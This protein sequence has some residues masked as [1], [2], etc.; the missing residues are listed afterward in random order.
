MQRG[1]DAILKDSVIATYGAL[2]FAVPSAGMDVEALA[3]MVGELP[4]RTTLHELDAR[5]GQRL[6]LRQH[7]DFCEAFQFEDSVLARFYEL[8]ESRTVEKVSKHPYLLTY[9]RVRCIQCT[10]SES[11]KTQNS[12]GEWSRTGKLR[13][14]VALS[15]ASLGRPWETGEEFIIGLEGDHSTLVKLPDYCR[16]K[17]YDRISDVLEKFLTVANEVIA[18]RFRLLSTSS[19]SHSSEGKLLISDS[20]K[21]KYNAFRLE[22][23]MTLSEEE[24]QKGKERAGRFGRSRAPFSHIH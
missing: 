5:I 6:R 21:R 11:N 8:H 13:R 10:R 4:A 12:S 22:T 14:L 16:E 15:S 24:E 7:L 9:V 18:S 23:D 2:F 17:R 3:T 20:A 1:A 19:I